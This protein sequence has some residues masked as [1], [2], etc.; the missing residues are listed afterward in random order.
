MPFG[1]AGGDN[2]VSTQAFSHTALDVLTAWRDTSVH[3]LRRPGSA[4]QTV[5]VAAAPFDT[6]LTVAIG[7]LDVDSPSRYLVG[8]IGEILVYQGLGDA[9][10]TAVED[11]LSRKWL[12]Q[13]L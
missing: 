4:E 7:C 9:D 5:P 11:Y 1:A 3:A 6:D 2:L 13:A 10:R 12:G 8:G